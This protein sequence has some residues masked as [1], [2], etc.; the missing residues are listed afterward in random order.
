MCGIN[1]IF[2]YSGKA[3]PVDLAELRRTQTHMAARGPDGA[4]EWRSDDGRVAFAHR[5]LAIIDPRPESAQPMAT[6]DGRYW[7]TFNGEIYNYEA[8]RDELV[9]QGVALRTH[10]DTEVMLYLYAREGAGMVRRLRGMFAFAIFDTREQALFL[11]R[12]P[13]GIKP[14]YYAANGG[15]F[16]FASQVKALL[17]GDAIAPALEPAGITG[18]LLWGSV[19]E[20]YTLYRDIRS[21][22]A[23]CAQ[24]VTRSGVEKPDRYWDLAE[25][26]V[27]SIDAARQIPAGSE[28]EYLREALRDSVRAH[29]VA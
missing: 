3:R 24:R 17:A 8:L 19:P 18:F 28:V 26:V 2:A 9:S 13:Y 6:A 25:V 15:T 7:I 12:D 16:R 29:L 27:R 10:S 23:G 11:A 4:G 20:P 14:L 5:R 22:P 21:L 1:G